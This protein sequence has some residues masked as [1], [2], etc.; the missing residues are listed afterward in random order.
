[1]S[2]EVWVRDAK[3]SPFPP[4]EGSVEPCFDII[5]GGHPTDDP[6]GGIT[7]VRVSSEGVSMP[8]P[9]KLVIGPDLLWILPKAATLSR[10]IS[11]GSC[12][13][14]AQARLYLVSREAGQTVVEH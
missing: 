7:L 2:A 5:A 13:T 11:T 4:K 6:A 8:H 12:K 10:R 9:M 1:M 3:E 14:A